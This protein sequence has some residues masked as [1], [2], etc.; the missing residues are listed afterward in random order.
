MGVDCFGGDGVVGLGCA[1]TPGAV[2][3]DST[4]SI[5]SEV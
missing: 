4:A 2:F 5:G 1:G 3:E